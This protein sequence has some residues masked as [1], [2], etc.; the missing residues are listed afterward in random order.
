MPNASLNTKFHP[1]PLE[2]LCLDNIKP[3]MPIGSSTWIQD[4]LFT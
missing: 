2:E 3:E 1:L 4:L